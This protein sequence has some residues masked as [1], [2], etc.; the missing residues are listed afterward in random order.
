MHNWIQTGSSLDHQLSSRRS[1]PWPHGFLGLAFAILAVFTAVPPARAAC[2]EGCDLSKFNTFLGDDAL[3]ANTNGSENTAVGA[4]ALKSNTS[5]FSNTAIGEEA[6]ANET[7]GHV[8]TAIGHLALYSNTNGNG[9][10][11]IGEGALYGNIGAIGNVAVGVNVLGYNMVGICNTAVGYE[12]MYLNASGNNNVAYGENA[13][14]G[15]SSGNNNIGIGYS[16]GAN[17]TTGDNNIDIGNGGVGGEAQVMRL[18]TEGK[19]TTTYIA[20]IAQTPLVAGSAMAVGITSNGQLGIRASSARFKE[21]IKPMSKA[22][23]AILALQPVTFRYKKAFDPEGLPQFG[24]VAEDVAKVDPDLVVRDEKG[25]PFTVRYDEVNAMLLNEFLKE[26][27]KVEALEATM[28]QEE[29]MIRALGAG[30]AQQ[31]A[32]LQKVSARVETDRAAARL[33]ENR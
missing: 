29:K 25:K 17:L 13:L 12:A 2:Q 26:H 28:A 18:G 23:E 21:A 6:L 27:H 33:V 30:L 19:Q 7:T 11:A 1:R 9:N 32:L 14:G 20:G 10:I 16:G 24:L 5:G 4:S 22:S 31:A 15:N 8:N 3:V